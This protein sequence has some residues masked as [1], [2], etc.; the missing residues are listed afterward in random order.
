MFKIIQVTDEDIELVPIMDQL[1]NAKFY[2]AK[3]LKS[4]LH[5]NS[6]GLL[7]ILENENN[8]DTDLLQFMIHC[9]EINDCVTVEQNLFNGLSF[10]FDNFIVSSFIYIRNH[11]YVLVGVSNFGL[12]LFD[13]VTRQPIS[14]IPFSDLA[15]DIAPKSFEIYKLSPIGPKGVHVF[16][17]GDGS[18]SIYWDEV[19]PFE[20]VGNKLVGLVVKDRFEQINGEIETSLIQP[21]RSGFAQVIYYPVGSD[22]LEVYVRIFNYFNHDKAKNFREYKIDEANECD[23][24]DTKTHSDDQDVD[25]ILTCGSR[26]HVYRVRLYPSLIL[27][28]NDKN[29]VMHVNVTAVNQNSRQTIGMAVSKNDITPKMSKFLIVLIFFLI[30]GAGVAIILVV[31][32]GECFQVFS[33]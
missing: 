27:Q 19:K 14:L 26:L 24:I 17:K 2:D 13:L 12:V 32:R 30:I 4:E 8:R 3:I 18:F 29:F 1:Y 9:P 20:T 5:E 31:M 22:G 23:S 6:Y 15:F 21:T 33:E 10:G 28:N 11:H 25:I 7:I 16:L